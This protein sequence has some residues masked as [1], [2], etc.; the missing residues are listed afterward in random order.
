MQDTTTKIKVGDYVTWEDALGDHAWEVLA[1]DGVQAW[2]KSER[3]LGYVYNTAAIAKLAKV[4]P[5]NYE[6]EY[7]VTLVFTV[8]LTAEGVSTDD[9]QLRADDIIQDYGVDELVDMAPYGLEDI[10][11]Y[12]LTEVSEA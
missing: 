12:Q 3:E 5:K 6:L 9:I 10:Y 4:E 2:V 7:E 1:V 11:D 8:N